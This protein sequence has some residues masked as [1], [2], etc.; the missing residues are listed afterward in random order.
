MCS[1]MCIANL[2]TFIVPVAV[3][4][5]AHIFVL[6]TVNDVRRKLGSTNQLVHAVPN[7]IINE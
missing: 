4:W 7:K 6:A 3:L 2:V 5:F 1:I